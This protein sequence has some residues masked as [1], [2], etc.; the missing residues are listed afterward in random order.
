MIVYCLVKEL[1]K[2]PTNLSAAKLEKFSFGTDD[3]V[4]LLQHDSES[5]FFTSDIISVRSGTIVT[6]L[7]KNV[8]NV[9]LKDYQAKQ[10]KAASIGSASKYAGYRAFI[11]YKLGKNDLGTR[12]Q[13]QALTLD[14]NNHF[15]QMLRHK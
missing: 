9:I 13:R 8:W 12:E 6:S 4:C 2:V 5:Y 15:A 10:D 11:Y 7:D 14:A 1:S 3:Y